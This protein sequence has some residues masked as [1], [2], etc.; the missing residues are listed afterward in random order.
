MSVAFKDYYEELQV[1]RTASDEEIK[2]AYRRLV[3]QH[4]PDIHPEKDKAAQ[5]QRLTKINEAYSVLSDKESRARYDRLG[6]RWKEGEDVEPE[7]PPEPGRAGGF[8]PEGAE[9]FSDFFYSFFGGAGNGDQ[10]ASSWE[11]PPSA[12][13]VEAEVE[14]PLEEAVHG[15]E[16]SFS[17][18]VTSACL[19]CGGTG[20][21]G[22]SFCR[23]CGGAGEVRRRRQ[24]R[25]RLP[26]NL[27][28]GSRI[29]IKGKGN[30]RGGRV[31]D[32]FIRV[33]L[34][35]DPRFRVA[36]S[37]LETSVRVMP[38]EA[39]LG[40]EIS[41]PTLEGPARVRLPAGTTAGKVLLLKGRGLGKSGG[42]RGDL[43]ARV[44]IDIP[45]R[46][47]ERARSL[48]K[49]LE[50]ELHASPRSR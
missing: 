30:E 48:Y 21:R 4:H 7:P 36:G 32:L 10:E 1:P 8:R 45:A 29:R 16:K 42:G 47:T 26:P 20:R 17:L 24:V 28:E 3:R 2:Q 9:A 49:D 31:G 39:A 6:E 25:V 50:K 37:D 44:E 27:R 11:A 40:A 18:E 13:D 46:V 38:W 15:V 19:D 33:R 5:T 43:R 34:A 41:V 14:L 35:K 12:L 23:V 22:R